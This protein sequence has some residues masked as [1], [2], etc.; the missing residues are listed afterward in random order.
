MGR[1]QSNE[2]VTDLRLGTPPGPQLPNAQPVFQELPTAH[3][4]RNRSHSYPKHDHC[5][6]LR[7][8]L[9]PDE[10]HCDSES[11]GQRHD[12]G[13]SNRYGPLPWIA[14][15]RRKRDALFNR[16]Q[17]FLCLKTAHKVD[18]NHCSH[19]N[20]AKHHGENQDFGKANGSHSSFLSPD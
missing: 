3:E 12:P 11:R 10:E 8:H 1:A 20:Q 2:W 7:N 13:V 4:H 6:D 15:V 14:P 18:H 16:A 5:R 17:A 9:D 19:G